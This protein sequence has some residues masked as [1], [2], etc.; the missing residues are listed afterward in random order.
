MTRSIGILC[1]LPLTAC[2]CSG[3]TGGHK[4]KVT[5]DP[6]TGVSAGADSGAQASGTG[7]STYPAKPT[8]PPPVPPPPGQAL[9]LQL[10][11]YIVV[12]QFGYLPN[13]KKVAVLVDPVNGWNGDEAYQPSEQL[14]LRAWA[15]KRLVF[16][17]P[18]SM[19]NGGKVDRA[20]GDRGWWFDFT[21][22]KTPGL[23]YIYDP[24]GFTRSHPFEIGP[25]VYRSP[26]VA[27]TKMFYFNRANTAKQPPYSCVKERCWSLGVD[28]M[29][30]GQDKEAR[31]V[32][33]RNNPKTARD[34]RGGWWD[35]GDTNKYVTFA[36]EAVQVL[37]T[38]YGENPA[39]F[40]DDFGIPESGNGIPD[41]IDE[42]KIEFDWLKRMQPDDLDGGVLI[43]V[44]AVDAE[45]TVPDV[46]KV[47]RFYYPKPCSSSTI[48]AAGM[49]AHAARM[50]GAF[51]P[52]AQYAAELEQRARKAFD[53]YNA[54]DKSDAC[55][56]QTIKSGDADQPLDVQ[57][58][59]AVVAA[60]YLFL[61]T[62][63]GKYGDYV[64]QNY[65]R[66]R[67]FH[68]DRW[69]AYYPSQGDALLAYAASP[70]ADAGVKQAIIDRKR[71]EAQRLD[72]YKLSPA[73][74][75]YRAYVR[76]DSYHWGSNQIRAAYGS[77]NFDIVQYK[78]AAP[79]ELHSY[80]EQAEGILH[81]FH[82]VNPMQV[83]Y[84][85]NMYGLGGDECV[86]E[87][88][89]AWFRDQE[90]TWDN[91]RTSRLGP[92]PGYVPGGPNTQYCGGAP[93][94]HA[95]SKSPLRSQPPAKAYVDSNEG[96]APQSSF[97]KTWEL[98]EPA[99][100]YQAN[101]VRLVSKFVRNSSRLQ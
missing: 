9:D 44:G 94:D 18:I 12:D 20:S 41:L 57:A 16:S 79:G 43:K 52:L 60:I 26:L 93:A 40:T 48:A 23:Y 98:S 100:Y 72:Y 74:D 81:W 51:Q 59:A 69:S 55:D 87:I 54:H 42:L 77:T 92:A 29:G 53:Y 73:R 56:D 14:E 83:V 86:D 34:L 67:P 91:A 24:A 15:D 65:T 68:D 64:K 61:Q 19:W 36:H 82:G 101:Y 89:H 31:S 32:T 8:A 22:V 85:T 71:S 45:T 95:C 7:T 37:L 46:S 76:E 90:R 62:G 66:V 6:P 38:A 4:V 21:S 5:P 88:F 70:N 39:A 33:E 30:P 58:Q 50:F 80:Q 25:E 27:A 47:P 28:Y 17:G 49:F 2:D 75:L 13:M 10:Q 99:I 97:D 63:D 3:S 35:A 11:R 78:L 84:L 1:I 96:W